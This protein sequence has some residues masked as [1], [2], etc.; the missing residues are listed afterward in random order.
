MLNNLFKKYLGH[1]EL[2]RYEV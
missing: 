1:L 2:S